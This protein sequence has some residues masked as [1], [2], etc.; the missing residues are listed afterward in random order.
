MKANNFNIVSEVSLSYKPKVKASERAKIS[1]SITTVEVFRSIEHYNQNI[2]LYECLYAM[3]LS[4][5]NKVLSVLMVS[6][7]GTSG[8]VVDI[9]KIAAPAILQNASSVI[10]THNHPSGNI[11][12]SNED[13]RITTKIKEGLKLLDI[14]LLDHIILT[15]ESY[16][17]FAD[18]GL[19]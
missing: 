13:K 8:T 11:Q 12:P 9:K 6:E 16:F 18:E 7:G 2:E 10:I 5:S 17:S 4:K 1:D 3:Y 19:I 15:D 14:N